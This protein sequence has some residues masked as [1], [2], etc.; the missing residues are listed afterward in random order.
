MLKK[1]PGVEA[2]AVEV[3]AAPSD[4]A[5]E[6]TWLAACGAAAVAK[7]AK[8]GTFS[9]GIVSDVASISTDRRCWKLPTRHSIWRR[10][11]SP[12]TSPPWC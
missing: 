3:A 9:N 10:L 1:E 4:R 5:E 12:S 11:E 8:S 6:A 7:S 2:F